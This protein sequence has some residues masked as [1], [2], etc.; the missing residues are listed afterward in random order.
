M[1]RTARSQR[2][3]PCGSASGGRSASGRAASHVAPTTS[4]SLAAA[5]A[6]GA[7]LDAESELDVLAPLIRT[8][9][10]PAP[11]VVLLGEA[12]SCSTCVLPWTRSA[13][14]PLM[15]SIMTA[16]QGRSGA[17]LCSA[18]DTRAGAR[19][20]QVLHSQRLDRV[21]RPRRRLRDDGV[22]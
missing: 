2:H 8:E 21:P 6:A 18:S 13:A 3:R 10:P 22:V 12:R 9:N 15:I 19:P 4:R 20:H 17:P 5:R 14:R 1:P 7:C 11:R 16:G